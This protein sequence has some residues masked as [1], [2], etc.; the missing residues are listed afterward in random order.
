MHYKSNE[1]QFIMGIIK[2]TSNYN[3][4]IIRLQELLESF[5]IYKND[6]QSKNT[7]SVTNLQEIGNTILSQSNYNNVDPGLIV[8]FMREYKNFNNNVN[9]IPNELLP[10]IYNI[11]TISKNL[12]K[13]FPDNKKSE[14]QYPIYKDMTVKD[15]TGTHN[16]NVSLGPY[17]FGKKR[18]S[19]RK[20]LIKRKRKSLIKRKH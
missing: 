14:I 20:S 4:N 10:I 13:E 19:K 3:T 11:E 5:C 12:K 15:K 8:S 17:V 9:T 16:V 2:E 7:I 6:L 18:K 1:L